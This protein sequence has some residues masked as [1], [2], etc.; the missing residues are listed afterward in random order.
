MIPIREGIPLLEQRPCIEISH[1]QS[2]AIQLAAPLMRRLNTARYKRMRK[3]LA[4]IL[5]AASRCQTRDELEAV[6]GR[7]KYS[8]SPNTCGMVDLTGKSRHPDHVEVYL[9]SGC[10][11][12][13]WFFLSEGQF[14]LLGSPC[15]TLTDIVLGHSGPPACPTPPFD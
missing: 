8:L 1:L 15:M 4:K 12:D 6:L 5:A 7:P 10:T 13:M 2:S 3:R 9:V 14:E 11:V